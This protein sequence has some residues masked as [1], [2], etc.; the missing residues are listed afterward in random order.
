MLVAEGIFLYTCS[1]GWK[2]QNNFT[3]HWRK[4]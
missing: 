1:K 4:P 3:C 2:N